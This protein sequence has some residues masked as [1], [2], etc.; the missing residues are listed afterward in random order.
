MPPI[1]AL[2]LLQIPPQ[3]NNHPLSRVMSNAYAYSRPAAKLVCLSC[4]H[5]KIRCE[6]SPHAPSVACSR[7]ARKGLM[8]QYVPADAAS[9][10][11][12]SSSTYNHTPTPSPSLPYTGPP[13]MNL[14]PR[15]SAGAY[16]DLSLSG[17]SSPAQ[18]MYSVPSAPSTGYAPS[19]NYAPPTAYNSNADAYAAGTNYNYGHYV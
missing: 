11:S 8:C 3:P 13:P 17:Q 5:N 9:S 7:C 10:P 4:R 19:T 16:P 12:S 2:Y 18:S 1:R 6:P 14:R 15:Y